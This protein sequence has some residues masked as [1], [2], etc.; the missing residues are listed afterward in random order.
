MTHN[1]PTRPNAEHPGTPEPQSHWPLPEITET[2]PAKHVPTA[3]EF[4]AV[5][6]SAE[7]AELRHRFRSFAFPMSA[8][9]LAWYFAYVLLS[10]FASDFMATPVI[11]NLNLGMILGL[12]QFVT[13]FAITALYIRHARKNLDPLANKLRAEMEAQR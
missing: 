2:A 1:P 3:D 7:F 9:F 13:T 4:S 8:A 5:A 12:A 11:G 6:D 10:V